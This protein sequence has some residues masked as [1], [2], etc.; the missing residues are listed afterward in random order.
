MIDFSSSIAYS[1]FLNDYY[2]DFKNRHFDDVIDFLEK[3]DEHTFDQYLIENEIPF[4][5]KIEFSYVF[6]AITKELGLIKMD[7]TENENDI[8]IIVYEDVVK[9]IKVKL[10][11]FFWE[12][13]A[14]Y[15]LAER[16]E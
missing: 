10:K 15:Q 12:T 5:I 8:E 11:E 1:R 9:M 6:T 16:I 14:Y 13:Q 4:E 2:N 3:E 7:L